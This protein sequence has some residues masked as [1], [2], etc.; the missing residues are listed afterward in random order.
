MFRPKAAHKGDLATASRRFVLF[1]EGPRDRD[2]LRLFAQ[3]LSPELA[4]AMDSCVRILGGRQPDRA[5]EL[6]GQMVEQAAR[7]NGEPPKGLCILDRDDPDRLGSAYPKN[8][9]PEASEL[10]FVIWKRRQIESYLLVPRAI[11]R[12]LA[13]HGN[14]HQLD[15]LLEAWLPDPSDENEFRSLNAKQVLGAR[16][17][18]AS[19][20]GRPL[21]AQEIVRGMTP[22]EIH[23][24]IK[25]V[26]AHVRDRLGSPVQ[27]SVRSVGL[28]GCG[29]LRNPSLT[30]VGKTESY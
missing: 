7:N 19:Y 8:F 6:F 23:D 26:L 14:H 16:G 3:K 27:P 9:D 5:A 24:D 25:A 28:R 30:S 22:L 10:E 11:G 29:L 12:C 1:V 15:H 4:R 18:I 20:L 2:V 13:R 17:P 21:R